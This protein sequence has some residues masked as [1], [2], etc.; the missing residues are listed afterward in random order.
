MIGDGGF[1]EDALLRIGTNGEGFGLS[2][3][4]RRTVPLSFRK[5]YRIH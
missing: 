3:T 2:I 1:P 4:V 5:A